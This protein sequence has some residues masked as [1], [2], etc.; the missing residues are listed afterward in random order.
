MNMKK[1]EGSHVAI[2]WS[3]L[4]IW[5]QSNEFFVYSTM[6]QGCLYSYTCL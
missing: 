5:Q 6:W 4:F 3:N 1:S 2:Y